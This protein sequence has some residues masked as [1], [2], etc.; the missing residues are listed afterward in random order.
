MI[1]Y[2]NEFDRRNQDGRVSRSYPSELSEPFFEQV[3]AGTKTIEGRLNMIGIKW[4]D[5]SKGDRVTFTPSGIKPGQ[6]GYREVKCLIVMVHIYPTFKS[7][8]EQEGLRRVLPG[9]VSI[10][11]GVRIYENF[12]PIQEQIKNGIIGIEL[13][14]ID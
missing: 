14:R 2:V 11:D 9:V 13:Q 4:N 7:L 6:P 5:I 12:Y 1:R 3:S 8:L 10:D